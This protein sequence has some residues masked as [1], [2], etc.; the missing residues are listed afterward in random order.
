[1]SDS[2]IKKGNIVILSIPPQSLI[3]KKGERGCQKKG[4]KRNR[5]KR[6]KIG[7]KGKKGGEKG[8]NGGKGKRE[9]R[10][11]PNHKRG[12]RFGRAGG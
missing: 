10:G 2:T 8:E 9:K 4:G 12:R 5:G 11:A 6:A 7:G 3:S 1:M